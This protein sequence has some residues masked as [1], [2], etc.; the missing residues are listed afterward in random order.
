M[1]RAG[2]SN[3]PPPEEIDIN[4]LDKILQNYDFDKDE[5]KRLKRCLGT[6]DIFTM[7]SYEQIEDVLMNKNIAKT[8]P[9]NAFAICKIEYIKLL[10]DA[11]GFTTKMIMNHNF[12][13]SSMSTELKLLRKSMNTSFSTPTTPSPTISSTPSPIQTFPPTFTNFN[14]GLIIDPGLIE[15]EKGSNSFQHNFSTKHEVY[16]KLSSLINQDDYSDAFVS[17]FQDANDTS[18]QDNG[19]DILTV[20]NNNDDIQHRRLDEIGN[21]SQEDSIVIDTL[22]LPNSHQVVNKKFLRKFLHYQ[23]RVL[24]NYNH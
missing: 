24:P 12:V 6:F 4:D 11:S 19:Y 13:R 14:Y 17:M 18:C 1:T 10:I 2:N 21:I 7:W 9:F 22:D 5:M 15:P 3:S 8:L 16:H 20:D 23:L